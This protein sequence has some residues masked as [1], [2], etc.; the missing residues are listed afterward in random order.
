MGDEPHVTQLNVNFSERR[1]VL[2]KR[3][4]RHF[5]MYTVE[6]LRSDAI[7]MNSPTIMAQNRGD[8]PLFVLPKNFGH[9]AVMAVRGA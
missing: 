7:R 6:N 8:R 4:E 2:V 5:G 3:D 9:C 1:L